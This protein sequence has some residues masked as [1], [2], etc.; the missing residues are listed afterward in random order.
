M[1]ITTIIPV[2]LMLV[3]AVFC[4]TGVAPVVAGLIAITAALLTVAVSWGKR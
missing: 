4:F 1:K 3:V 2:I